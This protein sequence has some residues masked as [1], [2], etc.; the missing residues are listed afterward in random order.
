MVMTLLLLH[1]IILILLTSLSLDPSVNAQP[2]DYGTAFV[3]TLYIYTVRTL[4]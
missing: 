3:T 1:S 4:I 2:N